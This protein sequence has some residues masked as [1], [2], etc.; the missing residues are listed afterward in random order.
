M[1]RILLIGCCGTMGG[2]IAA[3]AAKRN[4][5]V[6]AAG[7][8]RNLTGA[9]S[10]PVYTDIEQVCEDF[11]VIVD[12]STPK[13]LDGLLKFV[14]SSQKPIVLATTG[15][16]EEQI[17][18]IE[19]AASHT[20]VFFSANMSLGIS[21]M[22]ELAATAARVLGGSF[23][24]EIIEKHHNQK[25][26]APSGTA[27]MLAKAVA[28]ALPYDARYVYDRHSSRTKRDPHEIGMHSVRGGTIVGEHEIILAGRDEV[29]TLGHT[30]YSKAIF[31]NGALSAAAFLS[32]KPKGMYTMADVVDEV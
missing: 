22:C 1:T 18:H 23:D 30:A 7:V 27:L 15:Y 26:D 13:A 28:Q 24:V 2:V 14:C 6:V 4:D 3:E 16:T 29:I 12:F 19:E 5:C 21:L 20:A 32:K 11:D 25:V 17:I 31:A 8:D 9:P 10:F